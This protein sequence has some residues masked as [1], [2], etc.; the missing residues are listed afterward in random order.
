MFFSESR[1]KYSV[2]VEGFAAE[3]INGVCPHKGKRCYKLC[4]SHRCLP[5]LSENY[6]LVSEIKF[7]Q[8]KEILI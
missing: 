3:A 6:K 7:T 5:M 4:A 2:Y 8:R 1:N